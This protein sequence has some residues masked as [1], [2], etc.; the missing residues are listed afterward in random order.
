MRGRPAK[1]S[2]RHNFGHNVQ[3]WTKPRKRK[4]KQST[5]IGEICENAKFCPKLAMLA[6]PW[7]HKI[8]SNINFPGSAASTNPFGNEYIEKESIGSAD[9]EICR[10]G[11]QGGGVEG[12]TSD[13]GGEVSS[14][15]WTQSSSLVK[16][17]KKGK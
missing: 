16:R 1:I 4:D 6:G 12:V 15:V 2:N 13:E 7:S 10:T 17:K 3:F 11:V 14:S 9:F 8:V 5:R